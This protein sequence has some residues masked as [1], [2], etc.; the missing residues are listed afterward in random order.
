[1]D[2]GTFNDP[3]EVDELAI[4][5]YLSVFHQRTINK[6]FLKKGEG[7]RRKGG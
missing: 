5:T 1:M 7:G 3:K 4:V 6:V 2:P